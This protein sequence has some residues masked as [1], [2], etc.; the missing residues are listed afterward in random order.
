MCFHHRN[1]VKW[2]LSV[3][4]KT[5]IFK[6][7]VPAS[8]PVCCLVLPIKY[9]VLFA[10]RNSSITCCYFYVTIRRDYSVSTLFIPHHP[11]VLSVKL[12]L[13]CRYP[14][15]GYTYNSPEFCIVQ[16]IPSPWKRKSH[17]ISLFF[18]QKRVTT[19]IF[20]TA[21]SHQRGEWW[22]HVT[23]LDQWVAS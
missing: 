3:Q 11:I 8:C 2:G 10:N 20:D 18:R 1:S 7:C 14:R 16:L 23:Y 12:I 9:V 21:E 13:I 5:S 6:I 4:I 15:H 22:R 17:Q 19:I